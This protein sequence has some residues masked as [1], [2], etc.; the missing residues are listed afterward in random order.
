[1]PEQ[2]RIASCVES[3]HD[4][5]AECHELL[6]CGLILVDRHPFGDGHAAFLYYLA[7]FALDTDNLPAAVEFAERLRGLTSPVNDFDLEI[8]FARVAAK[9]KE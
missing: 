1:M 7:L 5:E 4:H 2:G 6:E 3:T 9:G 8:L